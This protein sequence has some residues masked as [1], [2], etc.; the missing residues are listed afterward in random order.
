MNAF[1]FVSF[2]FYCTVQKQRRAPTRLSE[3]KVNRDFAHTY[4]CVLYY[5]LQ[6][7]TI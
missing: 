5:F 7:E 3:N 4:M 2:C 1:I 6:E